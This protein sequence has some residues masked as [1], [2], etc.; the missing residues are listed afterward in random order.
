MVILKLIR[1]LLYIVFL[2]C[3]IILLGL[4]AFPL[5]LIL[6]IVDKRFGKI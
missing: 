5:A 3:L 2:I 6:P 4:I 1:Y